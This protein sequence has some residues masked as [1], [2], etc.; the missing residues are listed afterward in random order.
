[1]IQTNS[2]AQANVNVV[3]NM[4][5]FDQNNVNEPMG[6]TCFHNKTIA[7]LP[8]FVQSLFILNQFFEVFR[9]A[10]KIHGSFVGIRQAPRPVALPRD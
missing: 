6:V 8:G 5:Q 10:I 7:N 4:A 2:F 3:F 9:G 1:M